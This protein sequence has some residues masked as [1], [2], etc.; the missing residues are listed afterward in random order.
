VWKY[1]SFPL[2]GFDMS[3]ETD[4]LHPLSE[5]PRKA[6]VQRAASSRPSAALP[7]PPL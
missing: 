1:K 5:Y 6:P 2:M 7:A 4:E 3:D